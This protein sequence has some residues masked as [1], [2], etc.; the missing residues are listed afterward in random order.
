MT[1]KPDLGLRQWWAKRR[2]RRHSTPR[3]TAS[4]GHSTP[5]ATASNGHCTSQASAPNDTATEAINVDRQAQVAVELEALKTAFERLNADGNRPAELPETSTTLP[6]QYPFSWSN[7]GAGDVDTREPPAILLLAPND[8]NLHE[9]GESWEIL[10]ERWAAM[11]QRE[12]DAAY[13]QRRAPRPNVSPDA[14]SAVR[15]VR[16]RLATLRAVPYTNP[17]LPHV[18]LVINRLYPVGAFPYLPTTDPGSVGGDTIAGSD[19]H[20]SPDSPAPTPNV[21]VTPPSDA[22]PA[23]SNSGAGN[24][25]DNRETGAMKAWRGFLRFMFEPA[26]RPLARDGVMSR[27]LLHGR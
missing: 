13:L 1:G 8:G 23:I 6:Q 16:S 10:A 11:G 12:L 7:D 9:A 19:H 21:V 27:S 5:R 24:G 25:Q 18:T 26:A 17:I 3:V 4:N 15:E 22:S 2:A 20:S 14:V